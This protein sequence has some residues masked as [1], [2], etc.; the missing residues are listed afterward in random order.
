MVLRLAAALALLAPVAA[1]DDAAPSCVL[2]GEQDALLACIEYAGVISTD[3]ALASCEGNGGTW[4][5]QSCDGET[6]VA[7]CDLFGSATWY[8]DAYLTQ[9][10]TTL[11]DLRQTCEETGG[12]F[13]EL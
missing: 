2:T 5:D 13:T 1:C 11:T 8:Y 9:S 3:D 7:R 12:E 10:G 6:A 4:R